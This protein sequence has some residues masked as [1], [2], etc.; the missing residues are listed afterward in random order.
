MTESDPIGRLDGIYQAQ[1]KY[2]DLSG[3]QY[4]KLSVEKLIGFIEYGGRSCSVWACHC[5]CGNYI[6]LP[7]DKLPVTDKKRQTMM[8]SGRRLYDCCESC[9]Q[10]ICP[11]CGKRFSH[12][13]TS[14]V[15]PESR[16]QDVLRQERDAFWRDVHTYRRQTDAK[17]REEDNKKSRERYKRNAAEISAKRQQHY[18]SLSPADHE[19]ICERG[20]RYYREMKKDPDRYANWLAWHRKWRGQQYLKGLLADASALHSIFEQE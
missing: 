9:R 4:G 2:K 13:H 10:K 5:E 20:R 7:Y 19:R 1:T 8:R 12:S 18:Q 14:F 15:C 16:C 11:V 17:Y 6:E 3:Q